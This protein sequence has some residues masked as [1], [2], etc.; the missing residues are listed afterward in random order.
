L[1][2]ISDAFSGPV[3]S[4]RRSSLFSHIVLGTNHFD[5]ALA[6]YRPLMKMLE[7]PERFCDPTIPWAGWETAPGVR[8][9]L[10][11]G[12]PWDQRE[13]SAGNGQ[14]VALLSPSREIVDQAYILALQNGGSDE[15]APGLRPHYHADYYGAYFRDLDGN[16]LCVVCHQ[17]YQP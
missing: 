17:A 16:K 9:L 8:P 15:G 1:V 5:R 4:L 3:I 13:A 6:F 14:V 10:V 7:R 2:G 12:R 11:I